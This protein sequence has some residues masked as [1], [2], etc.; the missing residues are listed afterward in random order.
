MLMATFVEIAIGDLASA[1]IGR[2]SPLLPDGLILLLLHQPRFV[3]PTTF[4]ILFRSGT[5]SSDGNHNLATCS[6]GWGSCD[7]DIGHGDKR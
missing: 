5:R 3:Q 4:K 1:D 2:P 6:D 7:D